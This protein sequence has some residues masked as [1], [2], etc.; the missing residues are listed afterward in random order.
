MNR[1]D[2]FWSHVEKTEGCWIWRGSIRANGYGQ[3]RVRPRT[4]KAHRWIWEQLNGP[5]D[6][7][8]P[9]DHLCRNRACVRPDHLE[10]VTTAENFRRSMHPSAVAYREGKCQHG[11]ELTP[12]RSR[13]GWRRCN[14]CVNERRR[15]QRAEQR[16]SK[17]E[18]YAPA[19]LEAA[20]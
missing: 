3:F 4:Y 17:G 7:R 18:P 8:T 10:A 5:L 20:A 16:P 14:T 6:S 9:I 2:L 15:R 11:H 19:G 13:P 1:L 12:V